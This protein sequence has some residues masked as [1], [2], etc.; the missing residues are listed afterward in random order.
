VDEVPKTA[1]GKLFRRALR[2]KHWAAQPRRVGG[3]A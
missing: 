1:V 2:E 3:G